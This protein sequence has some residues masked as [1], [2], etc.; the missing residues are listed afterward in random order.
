MISDFSSLRSQRWHCGARSPRRLRDETYCADLVR[1]RLK[2]TDPEAFH[3][4]EL[5][6]PKDLWISYIDPATRAE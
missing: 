4:G 6:E 1:D 2:R 3:R 5:V